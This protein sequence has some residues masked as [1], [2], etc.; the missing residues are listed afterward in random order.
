MSDSTVRKSRRTRTL[1]EKAQG[2][3]KPIEQDTEEQSFK[4]R[5][6]SQSEIIEEPTDKI[7]PVEKLLSLTSI[8]NDFLVE[9]E[10]SS[11]EEEQEEEEEEEQHNEIASVNFTKILQDNIRNYYSRKLR[12]NQYKDSFALL[13]SHSESTT[14]S[15]EPI[16]PINSTN[17]SV[18][19]FKNVNFGSSKEYTIDDY[20]SYD[21]EESTE[22]ATSPIAST[23]TSATSSPTTTASS[24]Y[25]PK[26]NQR[27]NYRQNHLNLAS[28]NDYGAAPMTASPSY[29]Q[30]IV[31]ILNKRCILTGKASEMVSTGNFL[32]NDFFL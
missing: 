5:K 27:F 13:N 32:I 31:N 28:S 17:N 26:I 12:M 20:F 8:N 16:S 23:S 18:P 19:F 10:S 14:I 4:R 3:T 15:T 2:M 7:D 21:D 1:S 24:L 11:S 30:D 22:T 29:S 9:L 25:I 6:L